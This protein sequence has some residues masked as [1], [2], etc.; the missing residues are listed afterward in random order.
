MGRLET[1]LPKE[2]KVRPLSYI[3]KFFPFFIGAF[4]LHGSAYGTDKQGLEISTISKVHRKVIFP[5][6]DG[7]SKYFRIPA[8]ITAKNGDLIAV[9]DARRNTT[10]DLQHTRN[11]DIAYKIS[12]DN[13]DNWSEIKFM[14][15][16]PDGQVGSDASLI[17]DRTTG[18]IFCFY[19]YLDHDTEFNKSRP[20]RVAVNYRF[21][22]Q[23]SED[24]G[25]TWSK[26]IDI[27]D[28]VLPDSVTKRDF[29]FVTSGRGIQTRS[30]TLIHT[31]VHVGKGGYLFGSDDQGETWTALRD[32][33]P[34]SPAN[35]SKILELPDG[36]WMIN[37]RLNGSG[38]RY[39]HR[40]NDNGKNWSGSKDSSLPDPG[41]NAE[42]IL[43]TSKL[44]GYKKDRLLFVNAHSSKGRKNL[45]LSLS[46]DGGQTW[47]H[48]KCI[49]EGPSGYS[50][51]TICKNGDIGIFFENGTKM[52]FVRVP[53]EDLT[54]GKDKLSKPY[55]MQ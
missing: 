51:I 14:T 23:T 27:R 18:K 4:L 13:G 43:Y 41:C 44:N 47:A 8:I 24:H 3:R 32:A 20:S 5:Q 42:P 2:T 40:S 21:Y 46:Y 19:N 33:S 49:E 52:T 16:F 39:I 29:V 12:T 30:G 15:D 38:H 22:L 31:I 6:G 35:E 55:Q 25:K 17:L 54:D 45:V 50:S 7:G 9:I 53:L 48:K 1:G 11:I 10:R 28:Q 37:A 34:F 26:P 36:T